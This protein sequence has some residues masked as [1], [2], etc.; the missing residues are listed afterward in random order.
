MAQ[1]RG[2]KCGRRPPMSSPR[3]NCN[4]S[5]ARR[6]KM[7]FCNQWPLSTATVKH[8]VLTAHKR[9]SKHARYGERSHVRRKRSTAGKRQPVW[10][11]TGHDDRGLSSLTSS[12]MVRDRGRG[13]V[14]QS[15]DI[16]ARLG[17]SVLS[18]P[19]PYTYNTID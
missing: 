10:V 14:A 18:A 13:S 19:N 17:A 16:R 9:S 6:R 11:V 1:R 3:Q 15:F 12:P 8:L 5:A 7:F 2:N 4:K